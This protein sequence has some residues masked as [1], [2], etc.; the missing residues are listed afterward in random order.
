MEINC[1]FATSV[2]TPEHMACAEELG[3]TR[4]W[5][6]DSPSI[7]A[8]VWMVL[9][10]AAVR[11][12]KIRLGVAVVTPH[13]RHVVAN[14]AATAHLAALA[15]GR[16]D[17]VVGSGFTSAALFGR[18]PSRWTDVEEYVVALRALLLGEP[19]E[20]E[21]S[22]VQLLHSATSGVTIPVDVPIWV[23]AHGPQGYA[24]AARVGDGVVTNPLHGEA[25]V[26]VEGRCAITFHG[27]V[28][29]PC[30]TADDPRV[31]AAAGP[32]AALA[33]HLGVHGPLAGH[34]AQ[35][36]H[37]A[38]L[39]RFPAARRHLETHR[40]HLIALNDVDRRHVTGEVVLRATVTA[41]RQGVTRHLAG[42]RDAGATAVLY[43]PAGPDIERELAAFA[44]AARDVDG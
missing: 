31:L 17:L 37:S 36:A 14:A 11:T 35:L 3:Y 39:D 22:T 16:T 18:R 2:S 40:D 33:L 34:P 19:V 41:D 12:S 8:D 28:L 32:G 43:Q 10:L 7:Y 26:P 24:V 30:E 23:A 21:G 27:T 5:A 44:E 6:Y 42:L 29:D 9:A 15:P 13:V 20:W 4:A 1:A 38:E 25:R